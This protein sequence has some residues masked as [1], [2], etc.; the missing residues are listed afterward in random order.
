MVGGQHLFPARLSA[1]NSKIG[2]VALGGHREATL[3]QSRIGC[4]RARP[5]R[6]RALNAPAKPNAHSVRVVASGTSAMVAV[7]ISFDWTDSAV[8]MPKQS[9]WEPKRS[10][11]RIESFTS[12]S[13]P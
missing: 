8:L 6:R 3:S 2:S 11:T 12:A 1:T 9:I 4:S 5:R 13:T 10:C 7:L